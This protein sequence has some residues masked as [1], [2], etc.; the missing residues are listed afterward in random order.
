MGYNPSLLNDVED[1]A[2]KKKILAIKDKLQKLKKIR[3]Q[4]KEQ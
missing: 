3:K 4:A 1:N 2:L